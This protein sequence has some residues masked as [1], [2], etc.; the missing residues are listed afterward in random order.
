MRMRTSPAIF[1]CVMTIVLLHVMNRPI[2]DSFGLEIEGSDN[3]KSDNLQFQSQLVTKLS[4][5]PHHSPV[6]PA[7][8]WYQFSKNENRAIILFYTKDVFAQKRQ[9]KYTL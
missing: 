4:G 7:S 1:D 9:K 3:Q 8:I 2:F 6:D 5:I